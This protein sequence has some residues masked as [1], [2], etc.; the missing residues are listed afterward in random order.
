MVEERRVL[1]VPVGQVKDKVSKRNKQ[2]QPQ[3]R[4]QQH[5]SDV[6]AKTSIS[7]TKGWLADRRLFFFLVGVF[8]FPFCLSFYKKESYTLQLAL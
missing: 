6:S 2:N 4:Q 7:G 3:T 8:P 5:R 1:D